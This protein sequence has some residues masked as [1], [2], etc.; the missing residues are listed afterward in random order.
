MLSS[1]FWVRGTFCCAVGLC[2]ASGLCGQDNNQ[3]P[4]GFHALFNGQDLSGWHAMKT[5]N[6][7]DFQAL[8]PEKQTEKISAAAEATAKFWR[9]EGGE[10]VNDGKGP[11]LTYEKPFR[12]YEVLIDYK[13]VANADSGVYLKETPQVQ[14][15]DT[16][17]SGGKWN[18]GADKGSGGL[19]NNSPGSKGKDP[20]VLADKPFGE[21]NRLRIVQIGAKTWVWL[22]GE[23][24][25]SAAAM[26]NYWGRDLPLV[27]AGRIQLQTHGGEIRWK[28]IFAREI[29]AAEAN[30]VLA[31]SLNEGFESIFDGKSFTGWK[32]PTDNYEIV[33]GGIRCK[34]GKGGTI[35]TENEYADFVARME[36]KLPPGGNNGLAIRYPGSGDTAYVGMC[37]LQVLDSEHPKYANLDDRQYHG[38]AYGM[39][40]AHRGYLRDAGQ[41]NFQEVT[42]VGPKI[43]VELNGTM[44]LNCDVSEITDYMGKSPHP[45]KNRSKGH[46]GLAGH[47]DPVEYRNLS[48]KKIA[49]SEDGASAADN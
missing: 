39:K 9:V 12:D 21:W 1:L 35:Y 14:I 19:W 45:G 18:I 5:G 2:L 40:A 48:I 38:S 22:N 33:E 26:E 34:P 6:P 36:F 16:T 47:N 29:P 28:N 41:W 8:S 7:R 24:V 42:V 23:L 30:E 27:N 10:I 25:V 3:P 49:T 43:M 31:K 17:E 11:F 46:F 13:T 44:I 20:L 37:E 15:W 32:G 4:A